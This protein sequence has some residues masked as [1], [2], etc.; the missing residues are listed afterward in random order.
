MILLCV[1]ADVRMLLCRWEAY[2][3]ELKGTCMPQ[4][5]VGMRGRFADLGLLTSHAGPVLCVAFSPCGRQLVSGSTDRTVCIWDTD[6]GTL[7]LGPLGPLSSAVTAVA[8]CPG[9]TIA[10]G[11]RDGTVQEWLL[12]GGVPASKPQV[13]QLLRGAKNHKRAIL[14]RRMIEK[15]MSVAPQQRRHD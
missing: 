12:P 13:T 9:D 2:T 8:F 1:F 4:S 15:E 14:Q 5:C 11:T 7:E 6:T 3:G 10:A